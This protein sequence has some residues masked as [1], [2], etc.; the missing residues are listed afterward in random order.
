MTEAMITLEN[1][2]KSFDK[3]KVLNDINFSIQR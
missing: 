3:T 2:N 1:I